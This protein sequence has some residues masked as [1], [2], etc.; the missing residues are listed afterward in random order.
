ME[1]LKVNNLYKKYDENEVLKDLDITFKAGTVTTIIGPSGSGKSTLLRC[2]N[3]LES[4]TSGTIEY[5]GEDITNNSVNL[6]LVRSKIG[7]VFQSFNLF[8]NLTVLENCTI[9]QI[10]VL[11]RTKEE[12]IA[13]SLNFLNEVGMIDFKDR[14][15]TT[16]SG[17]QKQRVAIARTLSM[18]P[19]IILFDEPTSSLDPEMVNDVLDVIKKVISHDY[20]F[21]VVTHEMEFAKEVSDRILFMENGLIIAD[22]SPKEIW[23]KNSSERLKKY[24][25]I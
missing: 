1:L 25:N 18:N 23:N 13:N 16:L 19:E 7:M 12:S 22:G 6:N 24:L 21:I 8:N 2:L 9:G 4:V 11:N 10:K 15:V 5:H 14:K 17:G 3:Q 20:T